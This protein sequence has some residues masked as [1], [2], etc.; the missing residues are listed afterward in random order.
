MAISI[1]DLTP[2]QRHR[3][4]AAG[5]ADEIAAVT[6][7]DAP[8]PVDGW[9]ARDVVAHLVEWFGGFLAG[10][11]VRLPPAPPVADDPAVAWRAHSAAVQALLDGPA[12][13]DTF[14]HPMAGEHR[15]ADAVDRFYTAD[16]FMHTWDLA[17]ASGRTADLDPAFAEQLLDG[18]SG[19]EDLLRSSG[20][21]GPAVPVAADADAVS[22]LIGFI[23]RDP[24][25]RPAS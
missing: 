13:D 9:V 22:R 21:Y 24:A 5:F 1:G 10:G 11:G 15:L 18:M 19:I 6:D 4:V 8:T 2:A 17:A 20:Q 23:G 7:W 16:V 3:V 14:R 12:A 25:W